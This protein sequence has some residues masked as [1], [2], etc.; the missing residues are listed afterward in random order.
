[1]P[2]S[3]TKYINI[4]SA[5][6]GASILSARQFGGRFYTTNPLVSPG[7]VQLFTSAADVGTFFGTTSE[8]YLRAVFY[9]NYTS[10]TIT[11]P[12]QL[13][14]ARWVNV[15]T[16][17]HIYGGRSK[18]SAL[19][20]LKTVVAGQLTLVVDG[21][22]EVFSSISFAAA[23]SLA[24]VASELQTIIAA[25]TNVVLADATVTYDATNARFVIAGSATV[26]DSGTIATLSTGSGVTDVAA[27]L[28]LY[29]YQGA[30]FTNSSPVVSPLDTFIDDV[31]NNDNFG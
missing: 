19:S 6:A 13:S 12:Q 26:T 8:E 4:K 2:I 9:F 7:T 16:P 11:S 10:P 20:V 21:V 24:D 29:S 3:F 31:S 27:N 14:F 23:T 1:M 17:V 22:N 28:G 15:A 25:S 5:V 30:V 18:S